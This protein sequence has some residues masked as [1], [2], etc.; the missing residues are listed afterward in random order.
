MDASFIIPCFRSPASLSNLVSD[1]VDQA[2]DA[3]LDFEIVLVQDSNDEETFLLLDGLEKQFEAVRAVRLSR[4]FGQQAA[5]VAGISESRGD[6]IVTLDDDYQ[7]RPSDALEMIR[8]LSDDPSIPLVYA[9]PVAPSDSLSRVKSGSL[10]RRVLRFSGLKYADSVSPFRAFRGYLKEAFRSA[11]GPNVSVDIILG[12]VIDNPLTIETEFNVRLD[13]KSGYTQKVLIKLALT[14][15]LTQTVRP[16]RTGIH[17]GIFGVAASLVF[18]LFIVA[19]YLF[20][21]IAVPGFATTILLILL[22]GSLQLFVLGIIGI[23]VGEQHKRGMR[24]P[25]YLIAKSAPGTAMGPDCKDG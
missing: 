16:L 17:L 23:Y 7:H 9:R 18:G 2:R 12:W 6:I 14:I 1:L 3:G 10:F 21:G 19:N 25:A 8:I 15:L 5:T 13:G 20:G 4:N 22:L 11:K 24:Q